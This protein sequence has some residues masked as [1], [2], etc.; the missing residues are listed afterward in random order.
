[1]ATDQVAQEA[2]GLFP[3][4]KYLGPWIVSVLALVQV[5]LIAAWRRLRKGKIQIHESGTIEIGYGSFGPTIALIGTLRCLHKDVFV[6][7]IVL[8]VTR[9]KDN[10]EH[11][12]NCHAFRPNSI[13]LSQANPPSFEVASSFL[14][15]TTDAHKY[16]IFF[17]DN[18][19]MAEFG[20]LQIGTKVVYTFGRGFLG[21]TYRVDQSALSLCGYFKENYLLEAKKQGSFSSTTS[22]RSSIQSFFCFLPVNIS[23][24][25]WSF[26]LPSL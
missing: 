12:L 4:V 11:Y 6:D 22:K 8:Q 1:M 3:K 25:V 17:V 15:T 10:A 20:I 5:W 14:V 2:I 7:R 18:E 26:L 13:P 19:F 16:N 23:I 9:V 21:Q 24:G